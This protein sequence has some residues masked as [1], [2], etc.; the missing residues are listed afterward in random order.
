MKKLLTLFLSMVLVLSAGAF[1]AC[2]AGATGSSKL[3]GSSSES[4]S[5]ESG[6]GGN[7][8][9]SGSGN[10]GGGNGGNE[11]GGNQGA[12]NVDLTQDTDF[13]ALVSDKVTQAQWAKA[14]STEE[15]TNYKVACNLIDLEDVEDN[16]QLFIARQGNEILFSVSM[17]EAS[18][19]Q[20][21]EIDSDGK[22][23]IYTL[24]NGGATKDEF[25]GATPE[26]LNYF[27]LQ[28]GMMC[29]NFGEH[30][31]A[32]TYDETKGAY[33]LSSA[34]TTK[35]GFGE[36]RQTTHQPG[37]ISVKFAGDKLA[38]VYFES[39]DEGRGALTVFYDYDKTEVNLPVVA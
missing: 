31:S 15:T 13:V 23:Y 16:A 33:V 2:D 19:T 35:T 37:E 29:P 10:Q 20:Y 27:T 28:L 7:E 3:E 25:T 11:G 39:V 5:S 24:E 1:A 4:S 36:G 30:Y 22:I 12:G 21:I 18:E 26:G 34:V 17:G 32:F 14:F 6:N 8:G 9:G 38:M